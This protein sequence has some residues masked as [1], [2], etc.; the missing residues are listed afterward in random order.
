VEFKLAVLVYE[1]LNTLA[2]PYLSDDCQLV[3]TTGRCQLRSSDNSK[4]TITGTSSRPGD[5][6]F[7]AAGPR[8]WNSLPTHVHPLDLFLDIFHLKLKTYLTVRGTS[9][10]VTLALRRCENVFLLTYLHKF[11]IILSHA[12]FPSGR[13]TLSVWNSLP[14]TVL[15]SDSLA[16]FKSRLKTFLF[17][18]AFPSFSAH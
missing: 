3:A 8:L 17:S 7:A 14:K 9:V 11:T 2:P 18:Q 5:G 12:W 1:A 6:A 4:C 15:N 16:V 13:V 10:L